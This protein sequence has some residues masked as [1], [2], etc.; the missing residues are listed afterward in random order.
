MKDKLIDKVR[1]SASSKAIKPVSDGVLLNRRQLLKAGLSAAGYIALAGCA[2]NPVTGKSEL[3]FMSKND[4]ISIDREFGPQ[5]FSSDYGPVQDAELNQY[6]S[7]VGTALTKKTHR[8]DMPYSFRVTNAHYMNAYTFPGGS[9]AITRYL[10]ARLENEEQLAAIWGHELGH[11]N[12]RHTASQMTRSKLMQGV[13]G[14]TSAAI[15]GQNAILSQAVNVAGALGGTLFLASY[16]R[17]NERQADELGQQYMA[18]AQYN[19]MG[20]ARIMEIL[21]REHQENPG[22]VEIL[23][24]THPMSTE[25]YETTGNRAAT[26]YAG[27]KNAPNHKERY[28]DSTAG[29]R[30]LLPMMEELAKGDKAMSQKN[31]QQAQEHYHSA[32]SYSK[33]DYAA[34][35]R[36]GEFYAA[37]GK[38]AVAVHYFEDARAIYQ[39]EARAAKGL[40]TSY[41]GSGQWDMALQ[42][43][44]AADQMLPGDPQMIFLKGLCYE[45]MGHRDMAAQHYSAFLQQVQQGEQAQHAYNQ[46][47]R[48]GYI[49]P[50]R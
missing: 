10:I 22:T 27:F 46:L 28:M 21:N 18:A 9:A 47:I 20:M 24:A 7:S 50:R 42:E 23:F 17:D 48:W 35:C 39:N 49:R 41:A 38:E 34:N 32:L 31:V 26:S 15:G 25:R 13:L 3:S 45:G 40:G 29:I 11:V 44:S 43:F 37:T 30:A 19:P 4:E 14:L 1:E 36:I 8:P 2:V 5:Q 6:V 16:S 12:A 33:N